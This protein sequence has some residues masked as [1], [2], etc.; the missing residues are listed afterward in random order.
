M[1]SYFTP[2][3]DRAI[4]RLPDSLA[5]MGNAIDKVGRSGLERILG[6]T[7]AMLNQTQA[8]LDTSKKQIAQLKKQLH[9][10][11]EVA[12]TDLLTGLKN[13]RG[14]EAAFASEM[15]R[16]RRKKSV[17]GVLVVIDLDSFKAINDTY[18]HLAGDE[19]LKLVAV[20]LTQEV[21]DMDSVAR[22]GGDEFV[23]LLTDTST[24]L[25]LTRVQNIAWKL[26]HLTLIWNDTPISIHAS[27]GMKPYGKGDKQ[28]DIFSAADSNMYA[29]KGK[30]KSLM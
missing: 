17:G 11:E 7:V 8:E 4:K 3:S 26:N 28:K 16:T 22:L 9:E 20:A 12:T 15:D 21:R 5:L 2:S 30:A 13:R 10:L 1:S 29:E 19:C 14:F 24:E 23:L 27:V 25:L 6:T 18:G